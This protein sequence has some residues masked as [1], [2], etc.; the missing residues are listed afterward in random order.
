MVQCRCEFEHAV[1][2]DASPTWLQPGQAV[3][4]AW[5]TDRPAGIGGERAVAKPRRSSDCRAAGRNA[6]PII[7]IPRILRWRYRW[8]VI[9]VS[10]FR[11]LQLAQ[12]YRAGF[13]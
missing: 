3:G 12:H 2:A 10:A 7:G 8:V 11:K 4:G 6:G 1:A 9:R 5:P 13:V